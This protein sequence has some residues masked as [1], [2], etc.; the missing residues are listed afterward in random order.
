MFNPM[1]GGNCLPRKEDLVFARAR[2]TTRLIQQRIVI[3]LARIARLGH[4]PPVLRWQHEHHPQTR[5]ADRRSIA[6]SSKARNSGFAVFSGPPDQS[7]RDSEVVRVLV[8]RGRDSRTGRPQVLACLIRSLL[9]DF[10][11]VTNV[12]ESQRMSRSR[13]G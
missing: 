13:L 10:P 4:L 5:A 2:E 11:F 12:V 7:D 1:F 9:G 8:L 6:T 3:P